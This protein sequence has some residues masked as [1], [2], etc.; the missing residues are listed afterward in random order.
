MKT[1]NI[2][3][4]KMDWLKKRKKTIEDSINDRKEGI[5]ILEDELR[6]VCGLIDDV[7]GRFE[8]AEIC[9]PD[10]G[11][12]AIKEVLDPAMREKIV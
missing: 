5:A 7:K 3:K 2:N 12:E 9:Q 10:T 11:K 6:I 4:E 1:S 8:N